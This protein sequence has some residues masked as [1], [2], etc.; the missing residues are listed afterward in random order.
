LRD[1]T[2]EHIAD[3]RA[4][5]RQDNKNDYRYKCQDQSVFNQALTSG[6]FLGLH[7]RSPSFLACNEPVLYPLEHPHYIANWAVLGSRAAR[8]SA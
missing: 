1:Q 7:L 2:T 4:K 6:G 3:G 8:K 5:E